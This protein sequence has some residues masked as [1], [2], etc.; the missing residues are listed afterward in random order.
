MEDNVDNSNVTNRR[1]RTN[2]GL[3][4][5]SPTISPVR[6]GEGLLAGP[7]VGKVNSVEGIENGQKVSA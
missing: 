1:K 6:E 7:S 4:C 5:G 2:P 3:Y